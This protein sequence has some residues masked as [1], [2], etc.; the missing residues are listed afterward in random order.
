MNPYSI[1]LLAYFS[2]STRQII[3]PHF[4]WITL[5]IGCKTPCIFSAIVGCLEP[6][7]GVGYEMVPVLRDGAQRL[8]ARIVRWMQI[9]SLSK[10][11][12]SGPDF[13]NIALHHKNLTQQFLTEP[14]GGTLNQH[15]H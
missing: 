9:S 3:Y 1:R 8:E 7:Q 12:R 13:A 6:Y 14:A 10:Y 4:L 5:C 15:I 11:E 2:H